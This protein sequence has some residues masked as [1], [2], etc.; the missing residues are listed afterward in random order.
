[1]FIEKIFNIKDKKKIYFF[2]DLEPNINT[3]IKMGWNCYLIKREDSLIDVLDKIL[4]N[5]SENGEI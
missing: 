2:D 5:L 1:L 3:G 4:A